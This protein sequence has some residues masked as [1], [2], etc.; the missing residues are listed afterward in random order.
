MQ[1]A[2]LHFPPEESC[3][4]Y[5][6]GNHGRPCLV[7]DPG[8]NLNGCLDRYLDKAHSSLT[9]VLLT[10]GHYDHITGLSSLRHQA[11]VYL[12]QGEEPFLTDPYLNLSKT[13]KENPLILDNIKPI[14]LF[15][16]EEFTLNEIKIQ[17][18][19]TPF[20]TGGSVCYYLPEERVL[21]S[22]DTLFHLGIGRVDLPTGSHHKIES[23][24]RKLLS[25]PPETK[26]YPGHGENTVLGNEFRYNEYLNCL[27]K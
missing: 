13:W 11:P 22:G 18:I 23:S 19:A 17:I 8:S 21:F 14:P 2:K 9:A 1:I 24:L 27:F 25:L 10:H 4:T 7:I 6:V 26:V 12:G 5:V 15:D 16:G 3:N 20:H